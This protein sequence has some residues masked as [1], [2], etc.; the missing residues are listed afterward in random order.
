MDGLFSIPILSVFLV[1]VLSTY[2]TSLN[3]LFFYMTWS[4]LVLSHSRLRIELCA[5][6]G[7]RFIFYVLPSVVFFL[8]DVMAPE[9]AV[10]IKAHGTVGLPGGKKRRNISAKEFK[11]AA[12]SL[13]NLCLGITMQW[14]LE[15][16]IIRILGKRSVLSSSLKLPM[17]VEICKDLSLAL[18]AREVLAYCLHRWFLHSD[19]YMFFA[20]WHQRWH[21]ELTAPY[22]LTAHYD[23]PVCYLLFKFIPTYAPVIACRFHMVTYLFYLL[24]ISVEET[25][26]YS[27]YTIMPTNFLLGGMA[28]RTDLH[29]LV[30]SPGNYGLWGGMDWLLGT[31]IRES[32][33][34]DDEGDNTPSI[35]AQRR[36]VPA[37]P[38]APVRA[39][40]R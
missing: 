38:A 1:P 7:V 15:S 23:H 6:I 25:F 12:W 35:P 10:H 32:E 21:H 14:L 28:R 9:A 13:F 11:V 26:A 20:T 29:L 37:V 33:D 40:R 5:T 2:K 17:P 31:I 22:P 24:L 27:G 36:V 3:L 19:D 39:R 34:E 16:T 30:D 8:F 18:I 4:T